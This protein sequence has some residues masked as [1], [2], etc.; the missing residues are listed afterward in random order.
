MYHAA[1]A[2]LPLSKV[3]SKVHSPVTEIVTFYFA[4]D[5]PE[6]LQNQID[7]DTKKFRDILETPGGCTSSAGGWVLGL[8]DL[9][10]GRGKGRAFIMMIGWDS[11][12]AHTGFLET[13][14]LQNHVALITGLPGVIK[15]DMCHVVLTECH[16]SPGN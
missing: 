7:S 8:V 2:P 5:F 11:V 4:A 15:R 16:R 14:I 12:E 9:P 6:A 3:L 1:L 13:A 10:T